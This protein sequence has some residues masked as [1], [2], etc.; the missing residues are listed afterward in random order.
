[1]NTYAIQKILLIKQAILNVFQQT[2]QFLQNISITRNLKSCSVWCHGGKFL[3]NLSRR[4][5]KP[6]TNSS[7]NFDAIGTRTSCSNK[8]LQ[9]AKT[10]GIYKRPSLLMD[11]FT[12]YSIVKTCTLPR[13]PT[14]CCSPI[15]PAARVSFFSTSAQGRC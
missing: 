11:P 6:S 15:V 10:G 5:S 1:M 14:E 8:K 7:F 4:S 2:L 9:R 12:N 13:P 3:G